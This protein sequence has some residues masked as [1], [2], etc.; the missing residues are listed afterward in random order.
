MELDN[1]LLNLATNAGFPV[2]AV[3]VLLKAYSSSI[4]L[5]HKWLDTQVEN[6]NQQT[7]TLKAMCEQLKDINVRLTTLE[8]IIIN[9]SVNNKTYTS[10]TVE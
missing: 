3:I 7:K 5:I 2:V 1:I 4:P 9:D 6:N 8:R 10:T